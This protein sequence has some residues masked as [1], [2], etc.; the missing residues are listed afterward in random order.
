M[1]MNIDGGGPR[2]FDI[3]HMLYLGCGTPKEIQTAQANPI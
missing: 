2:K 3:L 1:Y